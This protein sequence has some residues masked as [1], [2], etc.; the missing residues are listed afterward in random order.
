MCFLAAL[1]TSSPCVTGGSALFP[2]VIRRMYRGVRPRPRA[3]LLPSVGAGS[4]GGAGFDVYVTSV[5]LLRPP[6]Y[7]PVCDS[8]NL[9]TC[10]I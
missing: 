7:L 9:P 8:D 10:Y 3:L 4:S 6:R 5:S 1:I 2:F